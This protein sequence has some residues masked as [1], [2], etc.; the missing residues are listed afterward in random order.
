MVDVGAAERRGLEPAGVPGGRQGGDQH[1]RLRAVLP[2]Y[3]AT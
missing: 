2:R 1:G 3:E